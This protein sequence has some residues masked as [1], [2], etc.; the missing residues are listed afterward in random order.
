M[1]A[2]KGSLTRLVDTHLWC[3]SERHAVISV[4]PEVF[5]LRFYSWSSDT[6]STW[7]SAEDFMDE[8]I[9]GLLRRLPDLGI[10]VRVAL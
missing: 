3:G 8:G 6:I 1:L 10:V 5:L 9:I 4:G 7:T 2:G